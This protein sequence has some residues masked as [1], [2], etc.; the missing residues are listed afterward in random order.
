MRTAEDVARRLPLLTTVPRFATDRRDV[1]QTWRNAPEFGEA[2][3]S[4]RT[5]IYFGARSEQAKVL[6][7]ASAQERDGKS[8]L[9]AGLGIAM[10]QSGQRTLIVDGDLHQASQARLFRVAGKIGLSQ[11]LMRRTPAAAA[12]VETAIPNLYLMPAGPP[13]QRTDELVDGA[14]LATVLQELAAGY[15]RILV[16]SPPL[17][18]VA[19]S[20]IIA[21]VCSETL[22]VLR[23]GRSTRRLVEAAIAQVASVAGRIAGAVLNFAPRTKGLGTSTTYPRSNSLAGP[24]PSRPAEG[25]GVEAARSKR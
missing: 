16:D 10:A 13:V 3:R 4:L 24:P 22:L 23:S 6:Q 14:R 5:V 21:A 25:T 9:T 2:M 11:V 12:I 18:R 8:L 20:R 1:V 19:D 7:I 17:L 15:D